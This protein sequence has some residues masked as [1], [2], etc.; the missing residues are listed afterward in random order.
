MHQNF[1]TK[2]NWP[3]DSPSKFLLIVNE[4]NIELKYRNNNARQKMI[5]RRS[6]GNVIRLSP[7]SCSVPAYV[8]RP[9]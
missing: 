9:V 5:K 8:L 4:M 7:V 3:R 2:M 1:C 6:A